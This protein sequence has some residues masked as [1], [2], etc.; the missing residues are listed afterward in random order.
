MPQRPRCAAFVHASARRWLMG[1]RNRR[2]GG[3]EPSVGGGGT[4]MRAL[5]LASEL[6]FAQ[7][8]GPCAVSR[9]RK[10]RSRRNRGALRNSNFLSSVC[11]QRC[12]AWIHWIETYHPSTTTESMAEFGELR[13][14]GRGVDPECVTARA[15]PPTHSRS[16][17]MFVH[18]PAPAPRSAGAYLAQKIK[19]SGA[20]AQQSG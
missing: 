14:R 1:P 9:Y 18:R 20:R 13:R 12:V 4:R 19:A 15:R 5:W 3:G 16:I 17:M 10:R 11:R 8:A 6:Q 2:A 7:R